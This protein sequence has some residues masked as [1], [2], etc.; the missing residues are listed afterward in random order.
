LPTATTIRQGATG[1]LSATA[2]DSKGNPILGRAF[3]WTSTNTTIATVGAANGLVS[4]K[5]V[6][7]ASIIVSLDAISD[8]ASVTVVP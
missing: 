4:A 2:V 3:A 6:G 1:Q 5:K 7:A 8:T